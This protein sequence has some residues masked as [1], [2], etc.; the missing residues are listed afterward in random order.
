MKMLFQTRLCIWHINDKKVIVLGINYTMLR[1]EMSSGTKGEKMQSNGTPF[2]AHS[3]SEYSDLLWYMYLVF[4]IFFFIRS[5]F[6]GL[7]F[8]NFSIGSIPWILL[9]VSKTITERDR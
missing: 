6:R 4:R 1:L 2:N 9:S 3:A 8:L 7:K 5:S